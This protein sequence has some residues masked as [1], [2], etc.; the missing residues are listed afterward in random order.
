LQIKA[1]S[2]QEKAA[3]LQAKATTSQVY[4]ACVARTRGC[5]NFCVRGS[6]QR[7]TKRLAFERVEAVQVEFGTQGCQR[8]IAS[9]GFTPSHAP[10]ASHPPATTLL[11]ARHHDRY[12]FLLRSPDERR[13][14]SAPWQPARIPS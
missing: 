5:L 3:S 1:A 6:V 11:S 7:L 13:A 12:D 10:C 2:L 14:W 8:S 9:S 4:A